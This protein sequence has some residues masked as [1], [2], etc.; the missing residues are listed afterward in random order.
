[1]TD[2]HPAPT[3]SDSEESVEQRCNKARVLMTSNKAASKRAGTP[4]V[5]QRAME[6]AKAKKLKATKAKVGEKH[7]VDR[8]TASSSPPTKKSKLAPSKASGSASRKADV[9][10]TKSDTPCVETPAKAASSPTP[11]LETAQD[12]SVSAASVESDDGDEECLAPKSTSQSRTTDVEI[13]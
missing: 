7:V 2:E 8:T 13:D 10:S 6:R 11:T 12:T 1:M 4:S 9:H 5:I 3:C